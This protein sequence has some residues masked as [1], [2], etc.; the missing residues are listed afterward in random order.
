MSCNGTPA[1]PGQDY[2]SDA[3]AATSSSLRVTCDGN[4]TSPKTINLG[5][6]QYKIKLKAVDVYCPGPIEVWDGTTLVYCAKVQPC[7]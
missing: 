5:G 3:F 7:S 2:T 1:T 4:V 6:G